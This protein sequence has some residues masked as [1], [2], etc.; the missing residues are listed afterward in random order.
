M[1]TRT[2]LWGLG[3][4]TFRL[5]ENILSKLVPHI[6]ALLHP[7][8]YYSGCPDLLLVGTVFRRKIESLL[9][10]FLLC[11]RL[12]CPPKGPGTEST[13][14]HCGITVKMLTFNNSP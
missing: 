4:M 2:S 10:L 5:A 6:P 8:A 9:Y 13:A 3:F 1:L 7:K 14:Q 11:V 12:V